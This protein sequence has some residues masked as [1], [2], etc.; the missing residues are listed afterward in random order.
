V[1][2]QV[3]DKGNNYHVCMDVFSSCFK[4]GIISVT[5]NRKWG[6]GLAEIK[7]IN[8]TND[9]AFKWIFESEEAKMYLCGSSTPS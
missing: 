8:W 4:S 3:V 2:V 9:Y 5:E 6:D 7:G 1:P